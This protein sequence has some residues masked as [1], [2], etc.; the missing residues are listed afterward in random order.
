VI[1]NLG[2]PQGN[3]WNF[4]KNANTSKKS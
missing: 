3:F 2:R 1:S 4:E